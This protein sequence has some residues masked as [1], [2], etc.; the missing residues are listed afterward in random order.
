MMD[1]MNLPA[2][3]IYGKMS[4][5]E[6]L[7]FQ[8]AFAIAHRPSLYLLDEVT[9]GMDPV[10]RTEFFHVLQQLIAKERVCILMSSHLT[11]EIETRTDYVGVMEKGK[12]VLFGESLD[13]IPQ[14]NHTGGRKD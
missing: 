4:R 1:A 6:R 14:V 7:K 10:F 13:I 5:G 12:L 2:D 8:L 11:A 3:K 9:A